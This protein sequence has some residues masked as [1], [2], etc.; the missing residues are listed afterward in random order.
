M[1]NIVESIEAWAG[2]NGWQFRY[3]PNS[4]LNLE[5]A[6]RE[7]EDADKYLMLLP[8]QRQP[9]YYEL[10]G[11]LDRV[12]NNITFLFLLKSDLDES[13]MDD[14][15][16]PVDYYRKKHSKYIDPLYQEVLAAM[17]AYSCGEMTFTNVSIQEI[18]NALDSNMDGLLVTCTLEDL[19]PESTFVPSAPSGGGNV[20]ILDQDGNPI[21][22]V[23]CGGTYSVIVFSGIDGGNSTTTYTNSIVAP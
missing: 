11:A 15:R 17:D 18:V 14:E 9:V 22:T 19:D 23:P 1:A 2:V 16:K 12:I 21:Q 13:G 20:T 4:V 5:D 10:G 8:V 7:T 3:A 6:V